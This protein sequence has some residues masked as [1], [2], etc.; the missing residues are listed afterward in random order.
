MVY[1]E[2][3]RAQSIRDRESAVPHS[4]DSLNASQATM[5]LSGNLAQFIEPRCGVTAFS[6]DD[7][8]RVAARRV[9][10]RFSGS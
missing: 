5:H 1:C 9:R 10:C 8:D 4:R 2:I 6:Y 3:V 7:V